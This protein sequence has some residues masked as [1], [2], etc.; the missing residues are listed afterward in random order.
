MDAV[1]YH[2]EVT[3]KTRKLT[4][5]SGEAR[6]SQRGGGRGLRSQWDLCQVSHQH[7]MQIFNRSSRRLGTWPA[8]MH[9]VWLGSAGK[10]RRL[11]RRPSCI[12]WT[13]GEEGKQHLLGPD[14]QVQTSPD[15]VQVWWLIDTRN[16][17]SENSV[18]K[19]DWVNDKWFVRNVA[20]CPQTAE[21]LLLDSSEAETLTLPARTGDT[22]SCFPKS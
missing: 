5:G 11:I 18:Y 15:Q 4:A 14:N 17:L 9:A 19:K 21:S 13:K 12:L 2:E 16:T 22:R 6:R 1:V 3:L 20:L 10:P 7:G 8:E